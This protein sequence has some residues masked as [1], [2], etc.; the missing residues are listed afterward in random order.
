M[1]DSGNFSDNPTP[2]GDAKTATLLE[3]MDRLGYEVVNVGERDIR[4]GY[5]EFARRT[6]NAPFQFISANIVDRKTEKPIF[7][8]HTVIDAVSP[9]GSRKLRVGVVG[10]VRYNPIFL[11]AGRD[12]GNIVIAHPTARVKAEVAAL[13]EKDVDMIVLLAA[14]HKEDAKRIVAE[15]PEID[16]V[17]GSYGGQFTANEERIG[18]T[19]LL[20]CGNRGQ[21]IGEVRV[22]TDEQDGS[23]A[24]A[25]R[26]LMLH[27]LTRDY[28]HDQ[29]MLDFVNASQT[30][31]GAAAPAAAP[32]AV[33]SGS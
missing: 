20:F 2:K 4:M 1:L 9:D 7:P 29:E 12:E 17:L 31:S 15:V 18:D 14:L 10:V 6:E 3:A 23:T 16:F 26:Q 8:P 28:P 25:E 33:G 11:K 30:K 32:A 27:L 22:F 13:Q 24:V 21:R 5:P 19:T